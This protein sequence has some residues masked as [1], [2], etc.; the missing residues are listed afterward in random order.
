MRNWVQLLSF[1]K[2]NKKTYKIDLNKK[3]YKVYK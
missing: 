1:F 3:I 2:H